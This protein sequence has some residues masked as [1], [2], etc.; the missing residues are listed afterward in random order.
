M[1][2]N[3]LRIVIGC[4]FLVSGLGIA[5]GQFSSPAGPSFE[6]AQAVWKGFWTAVIT[7]DLNEARKYVHSQRQHLF[8]GRHTPEELREM[9]S[10]MAHCRLDANPLPVSVE[11][12][13]YRVMC[14][15]RGETAESQVGLRRDVDGVWRLSV[16]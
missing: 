7:G 16:L 3:R 11:E 9:A 13:I 1:R 10:Q 15:Q 14:E 8:P 5:R 4:V 12:V 2:E 6:E